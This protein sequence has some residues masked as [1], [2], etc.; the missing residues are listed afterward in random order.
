MAHLE[1]V[2]RWRKFADSFKLLKLNGKWT[3]FEEKKKASSDKIQNRKF[4]T[5]APQKKY[6][7]MKEKENLDCILG[8]WLEQIRSQGGL[9]E[10]LETHTRYIFVICCFFEH[11]YTFI[12]PENTNNQTFSDVVH[13]ITLNQSFKDEKF[14]L[15]LI[16][17]N[18]FHFQVFPGTS[19]IF[20]FHIHLWTVNYKKCL[21]FFS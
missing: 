3:F 16:N 20:D 19:Q 13:I 4:V 6:K 14:F 18:T 1:V 8:I 7:I 21:P 10:P 15:V 12:A 2:I 5:A 17:F 9:W 11:F